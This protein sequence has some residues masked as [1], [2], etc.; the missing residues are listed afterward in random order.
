MRRQ[1]TTRV[2]AIGFALTVC[3]SLP[4]R[5]A[6][7]TEDDFREASGKGGCEAIPYETE[8]DECKTLSQEQRKTCKE[9]SCN[10][11][12]VEKTLQRYKVKTQNLRDAKDRNNQ[13]AAE[14]L[15][16]EVNKLEDKLKEYKETANET[17]HECYDCLEA[18][19]K[20]QRAFSDASEKVSQ[21]TDPGAKQYVPKLLDI[22]KDGRDEHVVAMQQVTKAADNCK[23]VSEI[24]W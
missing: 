14:S 20:V 19:E 17:V 23:W 7:G 6:A 4:S 24:S 11:S 10:R 5:M 9:F 1:M 13:E 21:E 12:D 2:L 3:L 16:E 15:E 22:Y 18:R 8:R